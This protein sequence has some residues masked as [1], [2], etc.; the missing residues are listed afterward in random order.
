MIIII[1]GSQ[2]TLLFPWQ[3]VSW[4]DEK[5]EER[6]FQFQMLQNNRYEH[7]NRYEQKIITINNYY[8][9]VSLA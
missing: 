1:S 5:W 7:D 4:S 3:F 2:N 8:V 6:V 9:T